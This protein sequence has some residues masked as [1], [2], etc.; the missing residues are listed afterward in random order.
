M[1]GSLDPTRADLALEGGP[2][3]RRFAANTAAQLVAPAVRLVL[4]LTLLAALARYLGVS[5]FGEYALVFA[6]V[7][8][9]R[10]FVGDWGLGQ[11]VLREISRHPE[12]RGPILTSA[13]WLQMAVSAAG[14]LL[15]VVGVTL[16]DQPGAVKVATA[17]WG[18]S[19][20]LTPVE[21]LALPFQADLRLARLLG[22]AML[23]AALHFVFSIAAVLL[24][25]DLVALSSAA[26]AALTFQ[27]VWTAALARRLGHTIG[28]PSASGWR[29]YLSEAWPLGAGRMVSAVQQQAPLI[30]LS[31]V[32]PQAVGI[33]SA[34]GRLPQQAMLVPLAVV[35][36]VFPLLSRMWVRDRGRFEDFL[37]TLIGTSGLVAIPLAIVG[38][39]LAEPV[40]TVLFGARFQES[41]GPMRMLLLAIALVIPGVLAGEALTAA[42]KQR[43]NL[44]VL[45]VT[46]PLLV[47][48]L[49]A[50]VPPLGAIGAALAV[51]FGYTLLAGGTLLMVMLRLG[52][53]RPLA[54]FSGGVVAA[55][56]GA[57]AAAG[58]AGA[59]PL[60]SAGGGAVTALV[61]LVGS[62]RLPHLLSGRASRLVDAAGPR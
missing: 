3:R 15:L 19:L 28:G 7:A 25:G 24:G 22:P 60:A 23:G 1:T 45:I 26:L 31:F 20:L 36:S 9:A 54:V 49:V 56:S 55:L 50:M 39:A 10:G 21:T 27:V 11:V 40:V 58:L 42:G 12:G 41:A 62:S 4:G 30:A 35:S 37:T 14:Y 43:A 32:G 18:L 51:L 61:I 38:A 2:F 13:L 48:A 33:Y 52:L 17:V 44:A 46:V 6:F 57:G 53:A 59:G 34:A 5:G 16:V 47:V 29:G 8:L